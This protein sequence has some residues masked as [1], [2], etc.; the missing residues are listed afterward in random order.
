MPE[1]SKTRKDKKTKFL[2]SKEITTD[3]SKE[4]FT[5]FSGN[6]IILIDPKI[7]EKIIS[8][9]IVE[10]PRK[11]LSKYKQVN[12]FIESVDNLY[13]M[14]GGNELNLIKD[15]GNKMMNYIMLEMSN[16]INSIY[17]KD[18]IN[19]S[20]ISKRYKNFTSLFQ[21]TKDIDKIDLFITDETILLSDKIDK[22]S[23][24]LINK[25]QK[26]TH[27]KNNS[28]KIFNNITELSTIFRDSRKVLIFFEK[29][30]NKYSYIDLL[31][32]LKKY[33]N[34]MYE[35]IDFYSEIIEDKYCRNPSK[36]EK[37]YDLFKNYIQKLKFIDGNL[38]DYV[39]K[40]D[41]FRTKYLENINETI[42]HC[43]ENE[44]CNERIL[45]HLDKLTIETHDSIHTDFLI[46]QKSKTLFLK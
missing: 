24:Q 45:K 2:L 14:I 37:E 11:K 33:A 26:L 22:S 19:L 15:F 18:T 12:H 29:N 16:I 21:K 38:N 30:A 46:I 17:D 4:L 42:N 10:I 1:C 44:Y 32:I 28:R 3:V 8:R 7:R 9:K 41:L 27:L 6:E 31:N 25:E 36:Y 13:D 5:G 34:E 39:I 20:K 35:Y 43:I 23:K 40:L